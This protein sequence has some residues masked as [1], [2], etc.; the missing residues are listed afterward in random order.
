M[1]QFNIGS[2]YSSLGNTEGWNPAYRNDQSYTFN[3]NANWMKGSH[4]IR[5]GFD[6]LHHLMNH[7]Q[8]ELGSGPRGSFDFGNAVTSLNTAAIAAAGG[9]Q[10]GTPSFENGWNGMAGF[11]LGTPTGSGKSSQFIKMD[12]LENVFG[13]YIRDRWRVTPKLTLNL[14]LRWELYPN[15]TRS[16]GLG[17]ESYDPNTNEVLVGGRGGIPQDNGVGYSKKLFA[18]RVGFAY[19]LDNSTVIRSGYGLTF[20]SHPWGAQALRGWY[21]LTIVAVFSDVNAYQPVTTDP[22]YVAAGVPNQPLGPTVGLPPICCPDINKGRIL[23]P[24]SNETGYPVANRELHRG[25]IQSWNFIIERKL[26][27]EVVASVGYVGTASVNGFAFLDVNA[28]QIPG[29]GNAGRPLFAKFGRTATTREW[30][31]RTHSNYHSLQATVN[32]RFASGLFLKGAYTYSHAIDMANYGDWTAFSWNAASVFGRNRASAA[33]NIPHTF[34]L[35]YVYELPFGKGK[36]WASG[37]VAKAILGDW[38]FNGVFSA[39]Q[40]RQYTLSAS[41]AALNM[42]GNAQTPDQVNPT[43]A[44]LGKAGDDGTWFDTT[45]FARP[46]GVRFG[47]VGRNTMRGPGVVNADLSLFR[48]FKVTEKINLQFRGESFNLSNTPHFAN[49]NGNANSSA[50]GRITATQSAAD[51]V[52]RSRE[53]RVGL[54]LGF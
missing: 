17:I 21:P 4:E 9:F 2:D 16:A 45:A 43:V 24:S 22:N 7:W 8:P 14:G 48:T 51:A 41:G 53:M 23:L 3:T 27:A 28:S 15:R 54:R 47:T 34:Q 25:Y 31:G 1:P 39:Y 36:K 30:D 40:G 33:N 20:H 32:R 19:Q 37:G 12:S 11:L 49:P 44:I 10:G 50:F 26:P 35:G 5:F 29:S 38:Q 6:F 13:L 42:P 46:T 18:P 52:G